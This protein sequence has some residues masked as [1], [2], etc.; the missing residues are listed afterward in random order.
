MHPASA[1]PA[2]ADRNPAAVRSRGPWVRARLASVIALAAALLGP[3]AVGRA[4]DEAPAPAVP[5]AEPKP[6]PASPAAPSTSAG[7]DAASPA[8]PSAA[9]GTGETQ[10]P[11][12]ESA[13]PDGPTKDTARQAKAAKAKEDDKTVAATRGAFKVVVDLSGALEPEDAA[14]VTYEPE[15]YGGELKVVEAFRGGPVEAGQVLV[16]FST[17][18]IDEQLEA[19]ARDVEIARRALARQQEEAKKANEA[20]DAALARATLDRERAEKSQRRFLETDRDIRVKEAELRLKAAEDSIKD[21]EEELAQ[22]RRMYGAG[23]AV[24]ET[25]RIVLERAQRQLDRSRISLDFQRN[26]HRWFMDVDLPDE[27]RAL[28]LGV[29][30]EVL[31]HERVHATAAVALEQSRLELARAEAAFRK[32]EKA[33]LD[34]RRDREALVL[35]APRAG[36]AVPG[37]CVRGKWQGVEETLKELVGGGKLRAKSP[38]F[39]IVTPGAVVV[40]TSVPEAKVLSVTPGMPVELRPA[41]DERARLAGRVRSVA[42]VAS[43]GGFPVVLE[44]VE[45]DARLLPG[46][47][48]KAKVTVRDEPDV[49]TVPVKAVGGEGDE[50]KVFVVTEGEEAPTPRVVRLGDTAGDRVEILE[51]LEAGERL[52]AAPP[53]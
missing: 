32:Q 52:L 43:D 30:R 12:K 50:R 31:S 47:T 2:P 16:R 45:R 11:A 39:T 35:K 14:E 3:A 20:S 51:G 10:D 36:L 34:L 19:V 44:F 26:R 38:L 37:A 21:Q 41:A 15:A 13:K 4:D 46:F 25:E 49:L 27:A 5:A 29:R 28:E 6:Q 17:E 24:E 9:K 22:L 23:D 48:V 18:K 1:R 42:A 33:L 40:R 7:S 53:K 8:E